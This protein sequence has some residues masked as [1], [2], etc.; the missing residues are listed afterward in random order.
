MSRYLS[1]ELRDVIDPVL[2]RNGYFGHPE[3]LLLTMI[4]D[5]R[6]YIRELG[7]R[8]ILKARAEKQPVLREFVVPKLNL[9]A[10]E[11]FELINWQDTEITE[12]PL[13]ADV[14]EADIRSFVKSGGQSTIE[15]ER[16]P[17]HTQAVERCVKI[18]TEA[19]LAVCGE[20]SRDGFIRSRLEGRLLMPV[21]NTKSD[22]RVTL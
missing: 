22:Y 18:V 21:F 12:P 20:V 3:N 2:Q 5:E 8:R 14:P 16:F 19:S 6:Q 9:D 1:K 4:A 7:L 13:T 10:N 11:Y 17:C 15:F